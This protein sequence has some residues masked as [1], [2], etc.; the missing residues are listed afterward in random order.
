M[1]REVAAAKQAEWEANKIRREEIAAQEERDAERRRNI[2]NSKINAMLEA[3]DLS[4][5]E[6]EEWVKDVQNDR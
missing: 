6:L 4:L 2:R 5:Y 3:H 1:T